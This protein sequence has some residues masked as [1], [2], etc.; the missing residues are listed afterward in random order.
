MRLER[1]S[2][3]ATGL[4]VSR[5][6]PFV[7]SPC[8]IARSLGV[9]G[10]W[11]SLLILREAFTGTTRFE[12]FQRR[13][14]IS[15]NALTQR[16]K[17]LVDNGVLE[18]RPSAPGGALRSY[19]LTEKGKDLLPVVVA[20]RQWGERWQ[21]GPGELA[22]QLVDAE[23]GEPLQRIAVVSADGRGLRPRDIRSV[24]NNPAPS[25]D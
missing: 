25:Q 24:L 17:T 13:L 10:E 11:W 14:G 12:D 23:R 1:W 19:G 15:R 8:P 22:S 2:G 21:F 3:I 6:T 18:K 4:V 5:R 16:L 20:L 7:A 9:V